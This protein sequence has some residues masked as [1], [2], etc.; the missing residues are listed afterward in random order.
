MKIKLLFLAGLIVFV[1]VVSGCTSNT[2]NSIPECEKNKDYNQCVFDI[3]KEKQNPLLCDK[4]NSTYIKNICYEAVSKIKN[5]SSVCE[6]IND[7]YEKDNC[8]LSYSIIKKDSSVCE[9]ILSQISK[10]ICY[11]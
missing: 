6:N 5:D 7:K 3:A 9:K 4:I 2:N 10:D 8:Y 11:N 1:V